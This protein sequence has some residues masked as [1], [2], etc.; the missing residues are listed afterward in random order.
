VSAAETGFDFALP[1]TW[2]EI[3]VDDEA[4]SERAIDALVAQSFGRRDADANARHELRRRFRAAAAR[5]RSAGATRLHL[6][7]E[8]LP[9][10]PLPASLTVYRPRIPLLPRVERTP[11]EQLEAVI[12]PVSGADDATIETPTGAVLRRVRDV[13]ADADSAEAGIVTLRVDY[14]LVPPSRRPLL[15]SF[16]CGLVGLRSDLVELFDLVIG[17]LVFREAARDTPR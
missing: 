7:R 10:V 14:W 9:G 16:A 13:E 2:W 3:P 15:L 4:A 5:A 8:L 6:C 17:T 12:E 11:L 1:G